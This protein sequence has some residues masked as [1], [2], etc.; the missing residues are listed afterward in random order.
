MF[1]NKKTINLQI[2]GMHCEHCVKRVMEAVAKLGGKADIDLE[3]GK[4][5]VRCPKALDPDA[6]EAAIEALGFKAKAE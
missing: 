4:A 3:T 2:D 6:L 5:T 1:N